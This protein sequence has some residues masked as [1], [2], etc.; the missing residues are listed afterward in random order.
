MNS[1]ELVWA[2]PG[3][4]D[5]V[6]YM[7]R[8]SNPANQDNKST[9]PKLIQYL[10]DHKHWSPFEMVNACVSIE[11]TRDIGRQI[12]RHRSFS[13]QEFSGRYSM[14]DGLASERECRIQDKSNRQNSL[15]VISRDQQS[16]WDRAVEGVRD[17]C[18]SAYIDALNAGVAKEVA[19]SLLPEGLVPSTLYMN[20]NL[21]SWIH[22]WEIRCAPET[23]KEHRLVAEAT[24]SAILE[25][26]P[27]I[28]SIVW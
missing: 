6:A 28:S 2:T 14:Y 10:I 18:W 19:R 11:T 25:K 16:L 22:Y 15:S 21:R 17:H 20:G 12:L 8:V 27:M 3:G 4:D 1:V 7:A 13:F 26:F 9:A 23:Q 24:R 5:L